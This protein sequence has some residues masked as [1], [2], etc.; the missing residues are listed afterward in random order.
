MVPL[1]AAVAVDATAEPRRSKRAA[2]A[3]V[4]RVLEQCKGNDMILEMAEAQ[5]KV[6]DSDSGSLGT[7][8]WGQLERR[9]AIWHPKP[10]KASK[11]D[12]GEFTSSTEVSRYTLVDQQHLAWPLHVRSPAVPG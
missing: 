8:I 9:S 12:S 11:G 5:D 6:G 2:A 10:T 4:E 3:G 1:G 7:E